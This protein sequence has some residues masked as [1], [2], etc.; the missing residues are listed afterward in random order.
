MTG[1]CKSVTSVS[2]ELRVLSEAFCDEMININSKM[3]KL[4]TFISFTTQCLMAIVNVKSVNSTTIKVF[5]NTFI[6]AW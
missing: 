1:V 6:S 4:A 2:D 3:D 5:L